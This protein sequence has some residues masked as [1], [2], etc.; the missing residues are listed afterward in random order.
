[1]RIAT[2]NILKGGAQRVHWIRMIEDYA[3]DL[4]LV[5]ESHPHDE[6]LPPLLYPEIRKQS[7]W[8]MVERMDGFP[9]QI[10]SMSE[11]EEVID[12]CFDEQLWQFSESTARCIR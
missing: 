10:S 8:E 3:V 12:Y 4:L 1:M 5:Q 6:H 11:Q 2:Y 9:E 7:V